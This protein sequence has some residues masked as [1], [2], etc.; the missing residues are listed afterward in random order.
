MMTM[1]S[2]NKPPK[3]NAAAEN[4]RHSLKFHPDWKQTSAF[5]HHK[6]STDGRRILRDSQKIQ[7]VWGASNHGTESPVELWIYPQGLEPINQQ[8]SRHMHG[9]WG[10]TNSEILLEQNTWEPAELMFLAPGDDP[11]TS[12]F[13]QRG[14]WTHPMVMRNVSKIGA[15]TTGFIEVE[16]NAGGA[17][18][19]MY[20]GAEQEVKGPGM[21][22]ANKRKSTT[23]SNSKPQKI[24]IQQ[25]NGNTFPLECQFASDTLR[26]LHDQI[27]PHL[28]LANPPQLYWDGWDGGTNLD[29][30]PSTILADIPSLKQNSIICVRGSF[31]HV[32]VSLQGTGAKKTSKLEVIPSM[33]TLEELQQR[34][35]K[36]VGKFLD[37]SGRYCFFYNKIPLILKN[38]TLQ[39]YEISENATLQFQKGPPDG[40]LFVDTG[41]GMQFSISINFMLD[42]IGKVK[43]LIKKKEGIP[44]DE[45]TLMWEGK[46]LDDDNLSLLDYQIP[47]EATL[48]LV[49]QVETISIS[50][51]T[52]E[53]TV[54]LKNV[55]PNHTTIQNLKK[56]IAKQLGLSSRKEIMNN[57]NL[58]FGDVLLDRDKQTLSDYKIDQDLTTLQLQEKLVEVCVEDWE[59]KMLL[60]E[61]IHLC[62][63][64]AEIMTN[65][66]SKTDIQ[67]LSLCHGG[68]LLQEANQ[69]LDDILN[70]NNISNHRLTLQL[71]EPTLN[72][73]IRISSKQKSTILLSINP[74]DTVKNAKQVILQQVGIPVDEQCLFYNRRDIEDDSTFLDCR[75]KNGSTLDMKHRKVGIRDWKGGVWGV[76]VGRNDSLEDLRTKLKVQN[77][78]PT[79]PNLQKFTINGYPLPDER[80]S[81]CDHGIGHKSLLEMEPLKMQVKFNDGT[82]VELKYGLNDTI[83]NAKEQLSQMVGVPVDEQCLV[84][85]G[86]TLK[87]DMIF[88]DCDIE[89][90]SSFDLE[91]RKLYIRDCKGNSFDLYVAA[92]DTVD[93]LRK[94]LRDQKGIPTD[95]NQCLTMNGIPLKDER[96]SLQEYGIDHNSILELESFKLQVKLKDGKC[97]ELKIAPKDTIASAKRKLSKKVGIPIEEQ[98]ILY[99]GKT[100]LDDMNFRGFKSGSG[101]DLERRKLYK[102]C[103]RTTSGETITLSLDPKDNLATLKGLVSETVD[104]PIDKIHLTFDG[105][106]CLDDNRTIVDY[107]IKSG[108][109]F[110]LK[111]MKI[112]V[113]NPDGNQLPLFVKQTDTIG[114]LKS[115]IE[116]KRKVPK[117]KIS[118][119]FDGKQLEDGNTLQDYNIK[120]EA[121]IMLNWLMSTDRVELHIKDGEGNTFSLEV[122]P[123]DTIGDIKSKIEK[124]EGIPADQQ[125]LSFNGVELEAGR[126]IRQYKIGQ[127]S[128]IELENI[129]S[130]DQKLL[131]DGHEVGDETTLA[132]NSI[133]PGDT[134]HVQARLNGTQIFVQDKKAGKFT[135]SISLNETVYSIKDKIQDKM[136]IFVSTQVLIFNDEVLN[137]SLSLSHYNIT[138]NSTVNLE[139]MRII[140]ATPRGNLSLDVV[141]ATKIGDIKKMV[142]DALELAPGMQSVKF[143]GKLLEDQATVAGSRIK[144]N[145]ILYVQLKKIPPPTDPKELKSPIS[146]NPEGK[147]ENPILKEMEQML[148]SYHSTEENL[149]TDGYLSASSESSLEDDFAGDEDSSDSE[150]EKTDMSELMDLER[151][152]TNDLAETYTLLS[153]LEEERSQIKDLK[154]ISLEEGQRDAPELK[155]MEDKN[156]LEVADTKTLVSKLEEERGR[157]QRLIKKLKGEE[158]QETVGKKGGR[159]YS[160]ALSTGDLAQSS[161]RSSHG[162]NNNSKGEKPQRKNKQSRRKLSRSRSA[163]G[164]LQS[165]RSSHIKSKTKRA[166]KKKEKKSSRR[167]SSSSSPLKKDKKKNASNRFRSSK[168]HSSLS[169]PLTFFEHLDPQN[170]KRSGSM[171]N[172]FYLKI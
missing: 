78:I 52:M 20:H 53:N 85:K 110:S 43:T 70:D 133:K 76:Y 105:D 19:M 77:G 15:K 17:W 31:V 143:T 162:S 121:A 50:I 75:V 58:R 44:C 23:S 1:S 67:D 126:T 25:P 149:K 157:Y 34:V 104:I 39:S 118:L 123:S 8:G 90:G 33:D 3:K 80:K 12:S 35:E 45:Q 119:A 37:R 27:I 55:D 106:P 139:R 131:F 135:I 36:Q 64:L 16:E 145:D 140:I 103:V 113:E 69:T 101:L 152:I 21:K 41:D 71:Q 87:D 160:K 99:K 56:L 89:S 10:F 112:C 102:A 65:I 9:I 42:T 13:I 127:G 49:E 48:E 73:T 29:H 122:G 120:H 94:K 98:C 130:N 26:D 134:L 38:R 154:Q 161:Q 114:A 169:E 5:V 108:S 68:S 151:M 136:K 141:P 168:G 22:Q 86:K 115:K 150:D 116:K 63:T 30:D 74:N 4:A 79:D 84:Y 32:Q 66:R 132:E 137:D 24:H 6:P 163:E 171:E 107:G 18:K 40:I 59:D 124:K 156:A 47:N 60:Q 128:I 93:D 138:N 166:K 153:S 125:R 46:R 51:K 81:L 167:S 61:N 144:Y 72:L 165:R 148:A 109:T 7:G 172:I 14:V 62:V 170:L 97:V 111:S 147:V 146:S 100:L 159:K 28:R 117:Q 92:C 129:P 11:P 164:L 82:R 155:Y 83:A 88:S 158:P 142:A 96:K 57:Y 91:R 54:T 95:P 2:N